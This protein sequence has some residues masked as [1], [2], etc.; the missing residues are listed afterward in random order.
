MGLKFKESQSGSE[1]R[2]DSKMVPQVANKTPS[3]L[4]VSLHITFILCIVLNLCKND[5]SASIYWRDHLSSS[6]YFTTVEP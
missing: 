3:A 6:Y 2:K 1:D 4:L 5:D